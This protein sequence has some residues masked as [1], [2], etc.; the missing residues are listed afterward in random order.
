[1]SYMKISELETFKQATGGDPIYAEF[2]GE[3]GFDFV[4]NGVMW[5]CGNE[6]PKFRRR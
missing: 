4:F 5:F 3:N 6:L 2:K 1:M